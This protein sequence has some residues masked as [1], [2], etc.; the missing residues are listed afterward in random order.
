VPV[1]LDRVE[2]LAA[3]AVMRQIQEYHLVVQYIQGY[4]VRQA[5][6]PEEDLNHQ[7]VAAVAAVAAVVGILN[8][9]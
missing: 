8:I 2:L 9:N 4:M 1:L 5:V 6:A 7:A 3:V